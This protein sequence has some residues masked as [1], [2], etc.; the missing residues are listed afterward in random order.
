MSDNLKFG[1]RVSM[2][3]NDP[4]AAPHLLGDAWSNERWFETESERD[5]ALLSMEQQPT[6]YRKGDNPSVILEKI[7]R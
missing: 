7:T 3:E 5:T 1:V 2:P 4:L 6:Y